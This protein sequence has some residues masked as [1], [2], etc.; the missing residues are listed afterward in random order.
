VYD[1]GVVTEPLVDDRAGAERHQV[2]TEVRSRHRR[3]AAVWRG[4]LRRGLAAGEP[5]GGADAGHEEYEER[6]AGFSKHR[7]R[8]MVNVDFAQ[9]NPGGEFRLTGVSQLFKLSI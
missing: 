3:E 8:A 6:C 4:G 7:L 5:G 2:D 1:D 9:V